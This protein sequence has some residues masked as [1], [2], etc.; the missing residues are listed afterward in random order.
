MPQPLTWSNNLVWNS[1]AVWNG[2]E[3]STPHTTMPNDNKIS[4][5]LSAQDM[6]DIMAAFATIKDKLPFLRNLT[7]D[8]RRS[9]PTVGTERGGMMETFDLEMDLHPDL[10]P[11][12]VDVPELNID[13]ALFSQLETIKVCAREICEGV[14]DTQQVVGSDIYLAYL[15]FYNSVKQAAKRAIVGADSIYQN[16]RRFFPRGRSTPPPAPAPNP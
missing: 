14:E 12:Y 8:E 16:L 1:G 10:I 15:S 3:A 13:R 7:K 2:F 11:A 6:T 5:S 9:L 4:A